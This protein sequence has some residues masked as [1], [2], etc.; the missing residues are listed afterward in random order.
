MDNNINANF[1]NTLSSNSNLIFV[2]SNIDNYQSPITDSDR[3]E[4]ILLDSN[5]HGVEQITEALANYER[6][7]SIHIISHGEVGSLQLGSTLLNT[8]NL[9][10]YAKDLENW[11]NSLTEDGDIL[12]YGC[13]IGE[14]IAGRDFVTH[15][16]Q[17]THA[18]IAASDDL[19]GSSNL[20]GD[21]ELEIASGEIEAEINTA[22][23]Y[24]YDSVLAVNDGNFLG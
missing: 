14:G 5:R 10:S 3:S 12:L 16:S 4:L 23:L 21:W 15:L 7:A 13:C 17:L 6:V 1:D 9:E 11:S 2:N 19:T 24:T 22:N 18:D 20:G 8:D